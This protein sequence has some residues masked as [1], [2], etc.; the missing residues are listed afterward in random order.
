MPIRTLTNGRSLFMGEIRQM[1]PPF[2]T[3]G[4]NTA[5][6]FLSNMD[7][8]QVSTA[9]ITQ[10]YIDGLQNDYLLEVVKQYPDRFFV[11]GLCEFRRPGYLAQA[12]ELAARGFR[13]IKIPAQR[14]LLEE[15][16]VWLNCNEMMEM[17]HF[18]ETNDMLLS[19]DLADGDVQ[20][21][22][23]EEVIQECPWITN[24]NRTF[25]Y[26]YPAELVGADSPGPLPE[27]TY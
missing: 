11:C 14:L 8:A 21:G 3:D 7:Y 1:V 9:V 25:R 20:T 26:G 12:R 22:E 23:L 24:C 4:R 2:I 6:I 13:A 16:R 17:F 19:I 10:E 18:M 5:E 27:C 15:G